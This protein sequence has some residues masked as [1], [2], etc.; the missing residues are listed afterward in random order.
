VFVDTRRKL[1]EIASIFI[2][3]SLPGMICRRTG[4]TVILAKGEE[5]REA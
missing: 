1:P 3:T 4:M 2:V 5:F